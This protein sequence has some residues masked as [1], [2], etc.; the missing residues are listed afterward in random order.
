[1][2]S[3]LQTK[4]WAQGYICRM[5]INFVW[6]P[7][8]FPITASIFVLTKERLIWLG[9]GMCKIFWNPLFK[10]SIVFLDKNA[11]TLVGF[12]ILSYFYKF[13]RTFGG[14]KWQLKH[15]AC[16]FFISREGYRLWNKTKSVG[17]LRMLSFFMWF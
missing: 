13:I 3:Y 15:V 17:L 5:S 12:Y 10:D 7:F 9:H 4:S 1:M 6:L 11:K 16:I 14:F 2:I 8:L